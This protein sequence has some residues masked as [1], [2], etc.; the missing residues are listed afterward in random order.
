LPVGLGWVV[1]I[2]IREVGATPAGTW[3]TYDLFR[4]QWPAEN[5]HFLGY[6]NSLHISDSIYFHITYGNTTSYYHYVNSTQ[7]WQI[8]TWPISDLQSFGSSRAEVILERTKVNG[9][10][11]DLRHFTTPIPW[12]LSRGGIVN[13][14]VKSFDQ[15]NAL[16]QFMTADGS[17]TGRLLAQPSP[18][19]EGGA[20]SVTHGPYCE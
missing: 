3:G 8:P 5:I 2:S 11:T 7:G 16:A 14:T 10:N 13:G 6:S 20:F 18:L 15:L 12:P 19:T 9:V 4:E 1:L 17:Q